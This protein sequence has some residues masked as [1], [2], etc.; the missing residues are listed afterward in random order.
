MKLVDCYA[1]PQEATPIDSDKLPTQATRGLD[2]SPPPPLRRR[3]WVVRLAVVLA[4]LIALVVAGLWYGPSVKRRWDALAEQRPF[5]NYTIPAGTVIQDQPADATQDSV[6]AAWMKRRPSTPTEMRWHAY[7][8][9]VMGTMAQGNGLMFLH[10]RTSPGGNRRIVAVNYSGSVFPQGTNC[11]VVV[12]VANPGTFA[13]PK[14]KDIPVP[15]DRPGRGR[16]YRTWSSL[17]WPRGAGELFIIPFGTPA[18]LYAG[19]VDPRDD[20]AFLFDY[21]YDGQPGTIV[22]RLHDDDSVTF[23]GMPAASPTVKQLKDRA[24]T[25]PTP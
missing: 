24:T 10:E 23:D 25:R 7:S 1:M 15:E 22:G 9:N 12:R 16:L 21:V 17:G 19:R 14:P 4:V 6:L 8:Y 3:R 2:Y 18:T 11:N 13:D 5:L 20:S